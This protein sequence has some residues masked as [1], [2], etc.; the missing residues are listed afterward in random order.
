LQKN[1]NERQVVAKNSCHS[2]RLL[3]ITIIDEVETCYAPTAV[4]IHICKNIHSEISTILFMASYRS[5]SS[6]A[7]KK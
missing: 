4:A 3:V 1:E 5:A 7:I 6:F 2:H